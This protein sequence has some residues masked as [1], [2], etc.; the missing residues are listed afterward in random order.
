VLSGNNTFGGTLR[1]SAGAVSVRSNTA[2]D[3]EVEPGAFLELE[4]NLSLFSAGVTLKGGTL[5]SVSGDSLIGAIFCLVP[6]TVQ[7]DGTSTL[8]VE[9]LNPIDQVTK[10]GPGTLVVTNTISNTSPLVLNAGTLLMNNTPSP[11][12]VSDVTVQ[13]GL[14]GGTGLVRDLVANGG[15]VDPGANGPGALGVS[16][17]VTLNSGSTFEVDLDGGI[18]GTDDDQLNV[19]GIVNINQAFLVIDPGAP[20]LNVPLAVIHARSGFIIGQFVDP[21][22][23]AVLNTGDI[24]TTSTG[25][26]FEIA[27]GVN[28]VFLTPRNTAAAFSNRSVASSVT[29]GAVATLRGTVVEP[30]PLDT[31]TLVVDWGDGSPVQTFTFPAGSNGRLVQVSHVY[32][33]NGVYVVHASWH[34]SQGQGNSADLLVSVNNL[35]PTVDADGDERLSPGGVLSRR[36]SFSDPGSDTWTATVDYGD[37]SGPQALALDGDHQF[38]LHHKYRKPGT[39]VVTVTVYDDDGGVSTDTFVV[40]VTG[41]GKGK[42]SRVDPLLP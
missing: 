17:D 41:H 14:L 6:S 24:I 37:A 28:D 32:G 7:V 29:E 3:A 35:A 10:E 34:D 40:T 13:G 16:G 20:P 38:R 5:W 30:D 23:N 11:L 39:Y 31:F 21:A 2:L 15:T 8:T 22:T 42:G 4:N 33:D 9:E 12:V 19:T 27:Y 26:Q 25:Q 36:G 1:V 18:P